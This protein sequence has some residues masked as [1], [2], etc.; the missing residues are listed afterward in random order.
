MCMGWIRK[1]PKFKN[2]DIFLKKNFIQKAEEYTPLIF[3]PFF[4][5]L[6]V[7]IRIS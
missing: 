6:L 1:K 5:I 4:L 3:F 2:Q 7:T